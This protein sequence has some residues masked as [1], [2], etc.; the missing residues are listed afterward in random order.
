MTNL[1]CCLVSKEL[2]FPVLAKINF[3]AYKQKHKFEGQLIEVHVV[4]SDYSP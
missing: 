4:R 2:V 1:I 3:F